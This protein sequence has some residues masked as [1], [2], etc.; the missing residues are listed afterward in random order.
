MLEGF[1]DEKLGQWIED[2]PRAF[3]LRRRLTP[4]EAE[5]IGPA[6]DCRGTDEAKDRLMRIKDVLPRQGIAMALA[7][8]SPSVTP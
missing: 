5:K 3:H 4:T 2:R 7:E 8:L 6:I 1:G